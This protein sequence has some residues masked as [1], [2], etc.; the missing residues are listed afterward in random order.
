MSNLAAVAVSLRLGGTPILSD[1]RF[2]VAAGEVTGLIGPNG[3]GKTTL[4]RMLAGLL[5]PDSGEILLDGAP[6]ESHDRRERARRIVYLPQGGT[7]DWSVTVETLVGM[8]RLPHMGPWRGPAAVD[9]EAIAAALATCDVAHLADRPVS[10][11]SGGERARVLLARALAGQPE[12]FLVDEPVSGFDPAHRLDVMETFGKLAQS[13][14]G[15]VVAMHDLSLAIRYCNRLVLMAGGL[16]V[17][18]GTVT[19][20]LSPKNLQ[21]YYGIDAHIGMI[22]DCPFLLPL[23]RVT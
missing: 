13:G 4:L 5:A 21:H 17:A 16:V 1:A 6:L 20:V 19:E 2:M 23:R 9:R 10:R 11:L 3:A 22:D 8:G 18:S 14:V 15:V 7:S 12:I